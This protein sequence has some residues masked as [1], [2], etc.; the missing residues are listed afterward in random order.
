MFVVHV[1]GSYRET[2]DLE[3]PGFQLTEDLRADLV[4]DAIEEAEEG[5]LE[6]AAELLEAAAQEDFL[7]NSATETYTV[8]GGIGVILG[9]STFGA[10]AGYYDTFYGIVGNPEGGHHGEAGEE[11]EEEEEEGEETVSIG[12]EQWRFDFK[13]DIALGGGFA[14]R[15]KIRAG[16]SDYTHTEFEGTEVGTVFE[17][18]TFEARAELLQTG[19]GVIGAQFASRDF[20]A[21]GEE[22]FVAPNETTQIAIF[23]AQEMDIGFAQ[24]EAAGRYERVDVESDPLG[25]ERDFDLFSGAVTLAG[26]IEGDKGRVGLTASRTERAPAG[27]ELF[28]NGPHI[29]TQSFEIGDPDL[30]TETA[31]GLEA[32]IRMSQGG[33]S[34]SVS[35]FV[36]AFEDYIFLDPTG[37]EEDDLP[38]FQFLQSDAQFFGFEADAIVPLIENDG[39]SLT[40]DLRASYVEAKLSGDLSG[41]VPRIPPLTLLAALDADV[42]AFTLRGEVQHSGSQGSVREFETETESFTFVNAYL[43][44]R[45]LEN[46]QNLTLQLAGENLFDTTGRRHSSFTKDF[47]TLPGRNIRVSARFSF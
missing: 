5:E 22:A 42:D 47:V 39:Y 43:T 28:A 14:D 32:F 20:S 7:P 3:I 11:G 18:E 19:G 35:A 37:E 41:P 45:P 26:E 15:L 23:T 31:W 38:V 33:A 44:W 36:Q 29:A 34:F 21:I 40:A 10:S 13:G 27:E 17:T 12:L 2:D 4:A 24:L 25:L 8:N 6:E 9:D 16:Y 46:N 1:D 30:G